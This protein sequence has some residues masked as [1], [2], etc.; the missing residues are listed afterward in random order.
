VPDTGS[1]TSTSCAIGC[2]LVFLQLLLVPKFLIYIV[3]TIG[4]IGRDLALLACGWYVRFFAD[5]GRKLAIL[6]NNN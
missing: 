2:Q 5:V 6:A 4:T 3:G 1:T